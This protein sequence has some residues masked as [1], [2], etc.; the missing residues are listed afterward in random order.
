MVVV[1]GL[2]D[3][4]AVVML[5]LQR[6]VV[7]PVTESSDPMPIHTLVGVAVG[8]TVGN[9]LTV[10]VVVVELLQVFASVYLKL[11]VK[12]PTPAVEGVKFVPETPVP[13]KDIVPVL[14]FIVIGTV[15]ELLTQ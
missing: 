4:V 11:I 14:G 9:G 10:T 8:V 15:V 6:Y 5:L 3:C 1:A 7:A 12:V 2:T 13:V